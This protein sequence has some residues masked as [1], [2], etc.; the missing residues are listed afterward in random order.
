MADKCFQIQDI[1]PLCVGLNIPSHRTHFP[2]HYQVKLDIATTVFSPLHGHFLGNRM[3]LLSARGKTPFVRWKVVN[4]AR[5]VV[6]VARKVKPTS[7]NLIIDPNEIAYYATL[8][9]TICQSLPT[10]PQITCLLTL[11]PKHAICCIA[12]FS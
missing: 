3:R 10:L 7:Q 12:K 11:C 5:K 8:T 2:V 4:V 1:L 9:S 6:N